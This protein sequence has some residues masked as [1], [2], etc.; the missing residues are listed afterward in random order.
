M[1]EVKYSEDANL[2]RA[3]QEALAQIE[4]L[5]YEEKLRQEG[6]DIIL[7]Y[8]IACFK[9]RCRVVTLHG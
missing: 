7:K 3:C 9:K 2:E 5:G 6:T 1:I 8:G 4:R